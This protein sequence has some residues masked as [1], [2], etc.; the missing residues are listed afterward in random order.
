[1]LL[2]REESFGPVIGIQKVKSDDEAVALMNDTRYGL[3]AGVYT[4]DEARAARTAGAR[5]CRQRLLELLR[6]RQPAPA[7]VGAWATRASASTLSTLRHLD[8]HPAEGVAPAPALSA[9][10][11][12]LALFDLDGTLLDGDTDQLWCE[13]LM[14]EG[15]L[16]RA[17]FAAKNR[18]IAERYAAGTVTP[19]EYCAFY[20]STAGRALGS[21][22]G[23]AARALRRRGDR[24]AAGRGGA[25]ASCGA[26]R[27]WR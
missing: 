8:L 22:V 11:P 17:D 23:A 1:M 7:L 12:A 16:D 24:A 15:V 20:A 21:A 5:Q 2:M 6:P 27:C 10:A 13:F 14:A 4:R 9:A 19:A 3:T 26:S 18:S 25:G